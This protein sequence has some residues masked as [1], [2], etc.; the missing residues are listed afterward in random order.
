MRRVVI[1]AV[2]ASSLGCAGR[3]SVPS[4]TPA[5]QVFDL[6]IENGRVVDGTG[7]AWF[8]GD[9]GIVGDRIGG[10]TTWGMVRGARAR[11]SVDATGMVVAPGSIDIQ[12]GSSNA[13]LRADSRVVGKV[14]Q[15]ITTEVF[16][17]GGKRT[18]R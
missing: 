7:A 9:L 1:A 8:Y 11:Q 10:A 14:T 18:R 6:V 13:V 17:D 12:S 5:G 3:S 16:G 2:L 4:P 15:G